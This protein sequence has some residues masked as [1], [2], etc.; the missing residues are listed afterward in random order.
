MAQTT[1]TIDQN[2]NQ[3]ASSNKPKWL[4]VL[5]AMGPGI[6]TAMAGNDAGGISTYSSAGAL[7]GYK[8]LWMILVM[9]FLLIVAQESACRMGV[10]TGKGFASL[11]REKFGV[12]LTAFAMLALVISNVAI[13]FSNFAGIA[14]GMELFGVP[15]YISLPFAGIAVW[16]LIMS[17]S[18]RRVEK[19][20]LAVSSVFITYVI[21]AFLAGPDWGQVAKSTFIPQVVPSAS[22]ISLTIAAIG[23][24]IAP[25]MIFL[26]Q[27]NVVDKGAGVESLPYQ[28][29]DAVTGSVLGCLIAWF[30]IITTGTILHPQGIVIDEAADAARALAPIAGPFAEKL[31]AAGLVA[32]SFLAACVLPGVTSSAVCEAFGWERGENRTWEEAPTYKTISTIVIISGVVVVLTPNINL[33]QM[34]VTAQVIAGVLLPVLLFFLIFIINDKRIMGKFTNGRVWN[35]L[36]WLTI[37]IVT[38]LTIAMFVLEFL[39]IG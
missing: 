15:K 29:I 31:F 34:M 22:F 19:I 39:N 11:I 6:L 25:W 2:Q 16:L 9:T 8:T 37:I 24:T 1:E 27:N 5:G 28:R 12:R 26:A 38:I 10:V 23:A 36:T 30:I 3:N 20:L 4:L 32:A 17:G 13:N 33:F 35:V 7:F 18:Y 14:S 21:A